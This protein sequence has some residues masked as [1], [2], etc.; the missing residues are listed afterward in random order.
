MI[1]AWAVGLKVEGWVMKSRRIPH[2]VLAGDTQETV[3]TKEIMVFKIT[4]VTNVGS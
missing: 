1:T 4:M 2:L 3:S